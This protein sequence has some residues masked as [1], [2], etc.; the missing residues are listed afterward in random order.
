VYDVF[1]SVFRGVVDR[2]TAID[3]AAPGVRVKGAA[4]LIIKIKKKE[5]IALKIF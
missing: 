4:K 2:G 1:C 3:T 5:L